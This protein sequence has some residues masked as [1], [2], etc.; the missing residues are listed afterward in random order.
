MPK[1]IR[2]W[3]LCNC[4]IIARHTHPH[5]LS[6]ELL[7]MASAGGTTRCILDRYSNQQIYMCMKANLLAKINVCK[8]SGN[9]SISCVV[10][11]CC[12]LDVDVIRVKVLMTHL[13][14]SKTTIE[15]VNKW[16]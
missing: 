6:V 12:D 3:R 14:Q 8:G 4:T 10:E 7:W 11:D 5:T 2:I 1:M 13:L 16:L 15:N 9:H